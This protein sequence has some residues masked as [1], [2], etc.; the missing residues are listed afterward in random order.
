MDQFLSTRDE[1]ENEY[2]GMVR[3]SYA[4]LLVY[5]VIVAPV[6]LWLHLYV[7]DLSPDVSLVEALTGLVAFF[8]TLA[9]LVIIG[10]F[11]MIWGETTY[12]PS[13]LRDN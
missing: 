9:A 1:R 8:S 10:R 5:L 11:M 13:R 6:S 4:Y 7:S 12:K 3:R 2:V